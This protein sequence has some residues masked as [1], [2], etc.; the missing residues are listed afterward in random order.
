V[1][2]ELDASI[3][4]PTLTVEARLSVGDETV[5]M[6]GPNGAG[7]STLLRAIAGLMPITSGRLS[8]GDAVFD[9]PDRGVFVPP[10]ERSVGFMFQDYALFPAMSVLENV[11]FGMRS[12]GIAKA[13]ARARAHEWLTR[14][15]LETRAGDR[16]GALSGGEAQ[17]VAFARALAPRPDIVVLDEP[18]SALD[19][20]SRPESRRT[21]RALLTE[22]RGPRIIV[23]HDPIDA[24]SLAER[25]V[26][27]EDGHVVQDG[28]PTEI[29]TNPRSRYVADF[30]GVNLFRGRSDGTGIEL[31]GG[32][33][34]VAAAHPGG[35]VLAVVHPHA[36]ALH[37]QRPEG[38][39]RNVWSVTVTHIDHHGE[40]VR[41]SLHGPPDLVAEITPGSAGELDVRPGRALWASLKATEVS[42]SEA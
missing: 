39:P 42:V 17:R 4:N 11:A 38:T 33:V 32:G 36:V 26:V 27:L 34:I 5:V 23:T 24:L 41:V 31:D 28:S 20:T 21:I 1:N 12:R 10:A 16:P 9:D 13:A 2:L 40:R 14:V 19:A 29:T 22:R 18:F 37:D 30:L 3:E 6:I 25:I 7:K 15:G 35:E 8:F